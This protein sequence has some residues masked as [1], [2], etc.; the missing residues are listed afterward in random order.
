MTPCDV[1]SRD[2][3]EVTNCIRLSLCV[4]YN[5]TEPCKE[6]LRSAFRQAVIVSDASERFLTEMK[7]SIL[8]LHSVLCFMLYRVRYSTRITFEA[9]FQGK[10]LQG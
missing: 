7:T 4:G 8:K 2:T 1:L 6:D 5:R 9:K 3:A 10:L